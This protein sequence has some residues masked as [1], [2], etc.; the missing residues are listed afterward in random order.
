MAKASKSNITVE[1]SFKELDV[2]RRAL[3]GAHDNWYFD[4]DEDRALADGLLKDFGG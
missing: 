4:T 3:Q 2:I 1:M